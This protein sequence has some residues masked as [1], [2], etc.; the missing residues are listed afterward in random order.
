VPTKVASQASLVRK[1]SGWIVSL[2]GG[3]Q[4]DSWSVLSKVE[5][6]ANVAGQQAQVLAGRR[7]RWWWD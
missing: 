2:S 5:T 7:D 4:V 3:V 6:S 1:G